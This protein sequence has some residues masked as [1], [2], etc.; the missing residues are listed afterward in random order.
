MSADRYTD[1]SAL[2]RAV[3]D[4]LRPL[5]HDR[6]VQLSSLQR[7]F[8]YDRL[9]CRVFG[10]EPERWVLKGATAMLARLGGHARHT[11][12]I[13]LLSRTG[14]LDQAEQALRAAAAVDLGDYFNFALDPGRQIV[15]GA[16]A[17]RVDVVAFLGLKEFARFH[18]DLVVS[19]A[20]TGAPDTVSALVPLNLPGLV[21]VDYRAYP[22]ADHIADKVRALF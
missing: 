15:Q 19:H 12:D 14:T 4:R 8:A 16:G 18:V 7:Q 1:P 21:S 6:G 9:L 17:M 3:A 10:A 20:I 22:L 13:D 5:A 11:R 2:R